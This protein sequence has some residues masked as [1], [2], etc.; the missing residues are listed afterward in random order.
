MERCWSFLRNIRLFIVVTILT[1]VAT[2]YFWRW[3]SERWLP[4]QIMVSGNLTS[5]F[6][7]DE[8]LGYKAVPFST[9]E[10]KK[11]MLSQVLYEATYHMDEFGW[12][13]EGMFNA[14]DKAWL[15]LGD[16]FTFG[17]GLLDDQT[18]HSSFSKVAQ[19]QYSAY[20]LAAPGYGPHQLLRMLE[21]DT[22]S[23][24]AGSY[25]TIV[26]QALPDH[27]FRFKGIY[28]WDSYGPKYRIQNDRPIYDGHFHSKWGS[29]TLNVLRVFSKLAF[30]SDTMISSVERSWLK[31]RPQTIQDYGAMVGAIEKL[32]TEKYEARFVVLLWDKPTLPELQDWAELS[33]KA[34]Q[35]LKRRGIAV[36]KVSEILGDDLTPYVISQDGHPNAAANQKIAA[37]LL[38]LPDA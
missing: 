36:I 34:Y 22:P 5:M 28:R 17:E 10:T 26:Y 33:D 19:G 29:S 31:N 38:A 18:I 14:T 2:E 25:H 4:P 32:A 15:F 1:L 3:Y 20:Q 11:S 6:E 13:N 12:R 27:L 21:T 9:V 7:L 24:Y 8:T 37:A 23:L 16:S 30:D 35:E